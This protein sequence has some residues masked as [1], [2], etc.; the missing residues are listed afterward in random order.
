MQLTN[1]ELT[2][3]SSIVAVVAIVGGYLGIRSANRNAL[4]IAKD[5]RAAQ[6]KSD[7][8]ALKRIAYSGFLSALAKLA[9][10]QMKF[11]AATRDRKED[12]RELWQYSI[13]SAQAANDKLAQLALIAPTS[14]H[15]MAERAFNRA[16]KATSEDISTVAADER[17]LILAMRGDLDR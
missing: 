17:D 7:L 9:D 3:A 12:A 10:D 15:A 8:D 5:T 16:L 6:R 2:A 11:D 1:Q 4:A 13:D 14:I